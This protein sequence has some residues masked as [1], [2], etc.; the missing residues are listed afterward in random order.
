MA[1]QK[2]PSPSF[3]SSDELV[4]NA[5][6]PFRPV[7][8]WMAENRSAPALCRVLLPEVAHSCLE[9][10]IPEGVAVGQRGA[11]DVL[12]A[13]SR[14]VRQ[15]VATVGGGE[16]E[17]VEGRRVVPHAHA[18]DAVVV[19]ER[20]AD[21]DVAQG[22]FGL[23]QQLSVRR[24]GDARVGDHVGPGEVDLLDPV[25]C[26]AALAD[27]ELAVAV[28]LECEVE[29]ADVRVGELPVRRGW[30]LVQ[31]VDVGG[32]IGRI[33]DFVDVLEGPALAEG[34]LVAD[35]G[36]GVRVVVVDQTVGLGFLPVVVLQDTLVD[37][38]RG[39][40]DLRGNFAILANPAMEK[41]IPGL[42]T[43]IRDKLIK[44][45][46]PKSDRRSSTSG[47]RAT[48]PGPNRRPD[49]SHLMARSGAAPS[50]RSRSRSGGTT[51]A[52]LEIRGVTK[53]FG[54]FVA[55]REVSLDIE[56]G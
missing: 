50:L 46:P 24:I 28:V 9:V 55:L 51:M 17:V 23:S 15:Q 19:G 48:A 22:A 27:P 40:E 41:P 43:D 52:Y 31:D 26:H 34:L 8:L 16:G 21:L 7:G 13:H 3:S 33:G 20:V 39:D 36:A 54:D 42:P 53:R 38:G 1:Y 12:L 37:L 49:A 11:E 10:D 18:P 25:R 14:I 56:E 5:K 44:N 32:R 2:L 30:R 6:V 35:A 29:L 47:R 4:P 45:G